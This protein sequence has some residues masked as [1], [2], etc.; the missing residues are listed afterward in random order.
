MQAV[1]R[2]VLGGLG[3]LG[4]IFGGNVFGWVVVVFM[5]SFFNL[6]L[7]LS[8]E[9]QKILPVPSKNFIFSSESTTSLV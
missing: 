4:D 2:T 3:F 7:L 1:L 8:L 5:F 6:C 9:I